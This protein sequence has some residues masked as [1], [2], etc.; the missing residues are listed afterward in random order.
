MFPCVL[1]YTHTHVGVWLLNEEQTE[2]PDEFLDVRSANTVDIVCQLVLFPSSLESDKSIDDADS[3]QSQDSIGS[4]HQQEEDSESR[5]T[6]PAATEEVQLCSWV[7]PQCCLIPLPESPADSDNEGEEGER[8]GA[9]GV[10][11]ELSETQLQ[12]QQEK[13]LEI[14]F[15]Y[16]PPVVSDPASPAGEQGKE[17]WTNVGREREVFLNNDKEKVLVASHGGKR[18]NSTDSGV[19]SISPHSAEGDMEQRHNQNRIETVER[20]TR[21]GEACGNSVNNSTPDRPCVSVSRLRTPSEK[22]RKCSVFSGSVS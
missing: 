1:L 8:E 15:G 16:K 17:E 18:S 6:G 3:Y 14:L 13:E 20:T 9:E 7:P 4:H 12:R 22:L 5:D 11:G 2:I 21:D 10:V 19:A